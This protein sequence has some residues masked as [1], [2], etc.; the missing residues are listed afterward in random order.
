[1]PSEKRE[2]IDYDS[3]LQKLFDAVKTMK[4]NRVS[5]GKI[6]ALFQF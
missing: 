1:M 4:S 5:L 6:R 3:K 2:K